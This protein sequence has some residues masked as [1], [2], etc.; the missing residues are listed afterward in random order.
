MLGEVVGPQP[1][2][3]PNVRG[4]SVVSIRLRR[5]RRSRLSY[6]LGATLAVGLAMLAITTP[7]TALPAGSHNV[8]P[9]ALASADDASVQAAAGQLSPVD[10]DIPLDEAVQRVER[11]PTVE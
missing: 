5:H 3:V 1:R 4:R 7:A 8:R 10:Y 2:E 9:R 11:Q 6:A